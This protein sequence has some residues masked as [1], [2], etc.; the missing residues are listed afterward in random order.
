M[1][2]A[3]RIK[4]LR[5][6]L[7]LTPQQMAQY[8]DVT[9]E[10]Y[11]EYESG[12]Q[13]FGFTFLYECAKVFG[14]DIVELLTGERPKLSHYTIVRSGKGLPI[15]RRE[16]FTYE[17]LAYRIKNKLAE[18]FLVTAPYSAEEQDKPI[19]LSRH[20]GQE[21]DFVLKGSLKMQLQD[22]V[23]VL[24]EGD[25][26]FYDSGYPHGMIATGGSDCVFLAVVIKNPNGKK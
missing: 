4:G 19:M 15:R 20:K 16:G 10:E 13:D 25:S 7:E 5:E 9:L 12:N 24:G 22:H 8:T 17:H 1:E 3:Q 11:L 2:I 18:P 14:V 6:I 26:I 23:E 21:F